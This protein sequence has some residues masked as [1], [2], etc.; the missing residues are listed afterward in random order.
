MVTPV[1]VRQACLHTTLGT[2][3]HWLVCRENDLMKQQQVAMR[4]AKAAGGAANGDRYMW[5]AIT[6]L[7]LQARVAAAG[8]LPCI[9][10]L[11]V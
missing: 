7:L 10:S 9:S 8:D 5:W 11:T 2:A 4:L 3:E 1:A 6:S